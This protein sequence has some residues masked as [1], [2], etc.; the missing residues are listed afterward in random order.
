MTVKA[1]VVKLKIGVDSC[2]GGALACRRYL[3]AHAKFPFI[4]GV[5]ES[6]P[7]RLAARLSC[8]AKSEQLGRAHLFL[9]MKPDYPS[10]RCWQ[11]IRGLRA[12][13][14]AD[15]D[16]ENYGPFAEPLET[17]WRQR[18]ADEAVHQMIEAGTPVK[19]LIPISGAR[20]P[21]LTASAPASP[22]EPTPGN[23]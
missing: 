21:S 5:P 8:D 14:N 22:L 12:A 1:V 3:A 11:P 10:R 23:S 2:S 7:H 9:T 17:E 6:R 15:R 13:L 16:R 19:S 4:L 20:V 18:T